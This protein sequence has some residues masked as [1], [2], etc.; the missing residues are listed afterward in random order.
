VIQA[1]L[2]SAG[3]PESLVRVGHYSLSDAIQRNWILSDLAS[4]YE[5]S[6]AE[7]ARTQKETSY[8]GRLS[9]QP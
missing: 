9:E 4:M 6:L 8:D 7:D 2:L 1:Q 5:A 3:S